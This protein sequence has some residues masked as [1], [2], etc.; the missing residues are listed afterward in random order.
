L[1]D[2]HLFFFQVSL[3][4]RKSTIR[5][6]HHKFLD[7]IRIWL[8]REGL[9]PAEFVWTDAAG[10]ALTP[11]KSAN[12]TQSHVVNL[13]NF[14]TGMTG[15]DRRN[16]TF[17]QVVGIRLPHSSLAPIAPVG[18]LNLIRAVLGIDHHRF[19]LF[20]KCSS[21]LIQLEQR[22]EVLEFD[23]GIFGREVPIGFDVMAIAVVLPGG[24]FLDE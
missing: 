4:L 2:G 7:Q 19:N 6:L 16:D 12:S 17:A 9:V 8:K 11:D 24:D 14:L 10:F 22:V 21:G 3:K 23:T 20:V 15:F 1:A 18:M 13:S 5:L